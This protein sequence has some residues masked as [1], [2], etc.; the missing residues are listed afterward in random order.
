M[1]NW[2]MSVELSARGDLATVLKSAAKDARTLDT[3]LKGAKT[4]VTGL[5]TA[6]R[7]AER[8]IR[9]L[10]STSRST[11][12]DVD[13]L[14]N[15]AREAQRQLVPVERIDHLGEGVLRRVQRGLRLRELALPQP[16]EAHID[17]RGRLLPGPAA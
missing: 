12:R 14:A 1:P 5:A 8:D 3:A 16:E 13:A 17:Q 10:G 11:A 9:K 4:G 6:S 2:N 7:T 15:A